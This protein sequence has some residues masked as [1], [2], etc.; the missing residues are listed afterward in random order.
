MTHH[1]FCVEHTWPYR[2]F[3][4]TTKSG[5]GLSAGFHTYRITAEKEQCEKR[6]KYFTM[7]LNHSDKQGR[8]LLRKRIKSQRKKIQK[9]L[10]DHTEHFI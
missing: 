3:E 10:S 9:I 7:R 6:V 5:R 4:S 1:Y 8:K 2:I